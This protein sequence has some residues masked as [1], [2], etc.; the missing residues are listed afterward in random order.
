MGMVRAPLRLDARRRSLARA[1]LS[2]AFPEMPP[3]DVEALSV[4]VFEHFG[5]VAAELFRALSHDPADALRRVETEG[6]A[7]AKDSVASDE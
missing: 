3:E 5:G 7:I 6:A 1:N 2:R 4:R